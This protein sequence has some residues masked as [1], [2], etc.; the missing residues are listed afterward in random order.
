MNRQYRVIRNGLHYT[1]QWRAWSRGG[2]W[3]TWTPLFLTKSSSGRTY[4]VSNLTN[5]A[6]ALDAIHAYK[7]LGA[8]APDTEHEVWRDE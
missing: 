4:V 3:G 7:C 2:G 6:E 8:T 5:L 1:P